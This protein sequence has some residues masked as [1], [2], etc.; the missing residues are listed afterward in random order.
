MTCDGKL[1]KHN[2][3]MYQPKIEILNI[4]IYQPKVEL[5]ER[6][7]ERIITFFERE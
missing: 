6:E 1:K 5:Q 3:K 2:T 4:K 7:R